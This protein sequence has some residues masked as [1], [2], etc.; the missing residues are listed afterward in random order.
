M[1]FK[2]GS[3]GNEKFPEVLLA[4]SPFYRRKTIQGEPVGLVF[5]YQFL[6]VQQMFLKACRFGIDG[7]HLQLAGFFHFPEINTP[8][9]CIPCKLLPAFFISK[10]K[11]PFL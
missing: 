3:K 7:M 10:K 1:L 2:E 9:L 4:A 8:A 5:V 6:D 11:D